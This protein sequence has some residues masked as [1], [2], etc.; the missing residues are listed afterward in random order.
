LGSGVVCKTNNK[1]RQFFSRK[2]KNMKK[3]GSKAKK[4]GTAGLSKIDS[5]IVG[6]RHPSLVRLFCQN[7]D[8]QDRRIFSI[9]FGSCGAVGIDPPYRIG[10][11]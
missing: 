2:N 6:E 4:N 10:F 3:N 7:P 8:F 1:W 9:F 11:L 5:S